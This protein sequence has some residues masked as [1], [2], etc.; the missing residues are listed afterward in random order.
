[1]PRILRSE[2]LETGAKSSH[3]TTSAEEILSATDE[4]QRV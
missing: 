1:M 3:R 4:R 2:L